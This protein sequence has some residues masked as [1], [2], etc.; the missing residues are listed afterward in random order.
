[1]A[2]ALKREQ[3]PGPGE[4]AAGAALAVLDR[5]I[6]NQLVVHAVLNSDERDCLNALTTR[7]AAA[8]HAKGFT[9]L[10]AELH[11]HALLAALE[12]LMNPGELFSRYE[13]N[14]SGYTNA[15]PI[16][17]ILSTLAYRYECD[18]EFIAQ[19]ALAEQV[20]LV[21]APPAA[22]IGL[23]ERGAAT[24]YVRAPLEYLR[25]IVA[26]GVVTSAKQAFCGDTS[27]TNVSL[28]RAGLLLDFEAH[29]PARDARTRSIP[30]FALY[31]PQQDEESGL[32][33]DGRSFPAR[34]YCAPEFKARLHA[35]PWPSQN[36]VE[37]IAGRFDPNFLTQVQWGRDFDRVVFP[38][39]LGETLPSPESGEVMRYFVRLGLAWERT[40]P[41]PGTFARWPASVGAAMVAVELAR[42]S[43]KVRYAEGNAN[44]ITND[45]SHE[46][47]QSGITVTP[48]TLNTRYAELEGGLLQIAREHHAKN[49]VACEQVW[50]ADYYR[51]T[52]ESFNEKLKRHGLEG[53]AR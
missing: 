42:G 31:L 4:L 46:L 8:V 48:K 9:G 25:S 43:S 5:L 26:W 30:D 24:E 23:C 44:T 21:D 27:A 15:R 10:D 41:K 40:P 50:G 12:V 6:W 7:I 18:F 22:L 53:W 34:P 49:Q 29:G 14:Q 38:Y 37:R 39:R 47:A 11:K 28:L 20:R 2:K 13:C 1:M 45:V 35:Y 3:I 36:A 19:T 17:H 16:F 32:I 51:S 33:G 52:I